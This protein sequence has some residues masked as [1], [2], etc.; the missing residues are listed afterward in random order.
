MLAQERLRAE[1]AI[2]REKLRAML[3]EKA[4]RD[5]ALGS[6]YIAAKAEKRNLERAV[7]AERRLAYKNWQENIAKLRN[8]RIEQ[9]AVEA[10]ADFMKIMRDTIDDGRFALSADEE[11]FLIEVRPSNLGT[12]LE[13]DYDV[14]PRNITRCL[15]KI[16]ENNS[17]FFTDEYRGTV[18]W[19]DCTPHI[20]LRI[21]ARDLSARDGG[22]ARE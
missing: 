16:V 20:T 6:E 7:L 13:N 2:G 17:E 19:N 4:A 3:A 9:A 14:H 5:A 21:Q 18:R 11:G 22:G 12:L 8:A 15:K 10:R 1:M